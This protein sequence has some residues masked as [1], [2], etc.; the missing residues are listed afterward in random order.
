MQE[1]TPDNAQSSDTAES[2]NSKGLQGGSLQFQT[3]SEQDNRKGS[4]GY[5]P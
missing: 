1:Q 4:G 5:A 2:G 3:L